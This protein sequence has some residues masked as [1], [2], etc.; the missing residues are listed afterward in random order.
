MINNNFFTKMLNYINLFGV[1]AF[2][3]LITL[4][5]NIST[6][7]KIKITD[8][9]NINNINQYLYFFP[10]KEVILCSDKI[11]TNSEINLIP[12]ELKLKENE[13]TCMINLNKNNLKEK[14]FKINLHIMKPLSNNSIKDSIDI[15]LGDSL[16]YKN[17]LFFANKEK[18]AQNNYTKNILV[19][20]KNNEE[21]YFSNNCEVNDIKDCNFQPV[22]DSLF[23]GNHLMLNL[24]LNEPN[25]QVSFIEKKAN[26][27]TN[28]NS[29]SKIF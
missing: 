14:Y 27:N 8:L 21:V 5:S 22:K 23:K 13:F 24:K 6:N 4:T 25:K 29:N 15:F 7:D 16:I 10:Q 17:L 2:I 12:N 26:T 11:F 1:I 3:T 9:A 20:I 18:E 28:E 19:K